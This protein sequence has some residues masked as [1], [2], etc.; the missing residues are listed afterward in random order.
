MSSTTDY[1]LAFSSFYKAAYAQET[2]ADRKFTV[3]LRK[4]PPGL[5]QTCGYGVSLRTDGLEGLKRAM[6]LLEE[7]EIRHRGVFS[8]RREAN[9]VIY[10]KVYL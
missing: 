4:L 6:R 1:L 2:L 9:R 5:L 10:D 3:S 7:R 8:P